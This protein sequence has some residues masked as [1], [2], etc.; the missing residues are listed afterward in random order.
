MFASCEE[1]GHNM[2]TSGKMLGGGPGAM[3]E[4]ANVKVPCISNVYEKGRKRGE[5]TPG[6]RRNGGVVQ[7]G[8]IPYFLNYV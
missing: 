3:Q 7:R 6:E 4:E 1:T 8:V 5:V 2:V